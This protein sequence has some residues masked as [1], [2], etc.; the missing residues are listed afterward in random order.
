[1]DFLGKDA[2]EKPK[3]GGSNE[4]SGSASP[5]DFAREL[6]EY[7]NKKMEMDKIRHEEQED[8]ARAT[9]E[10]PPNIIPPE[11]RYLPIPENRPQPMET[12]EMS[13]FPP[14]FMQAYPPFPV[15]VPVADNKSPPVVLGK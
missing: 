12:P 6:A 1:L 7:K 13:E 9:I 8:L 2:R 10:R 4:D 15:P 11:L 5:F 14:A 3:I